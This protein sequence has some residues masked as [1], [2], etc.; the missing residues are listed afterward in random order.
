MA[1]QTMPVFCA[2][3]MKFE[4]QANVQKIEVKF[5]NWVALIYNTLGFK[6]MDVI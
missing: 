3:G 1:K 6:H 2:N 4:P 5:F